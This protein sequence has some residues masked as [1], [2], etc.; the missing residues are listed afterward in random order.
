MPESSNR[1]PATL[2]AAV[3]LLAVE[4][5][6]LVGLTLVLLYG[7]LRGAAQ[8]QQGAW[9]VIAYTAVIA[10]TLGGLARALHRRRGFARGPAIVG[11]LLLLPVG[12]TMATNGQPVLGPV[13]VLV[14]LAGAALLLTPATRLAMNPFGPSAAAGTP[15]A[16]ETKP[17]PVK[18]A[19]QVSVAG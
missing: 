1:T 2:R 16:P 10:A 13:V 14:G 6:V 5:V 12:Y 9:G 17:A 7:V 4:A 19:R 15:T 18:R 11:H 3:W 8:T